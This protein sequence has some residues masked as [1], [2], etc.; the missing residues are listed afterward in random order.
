MRQ[1]IFMVHILFPSLLF[2]SAAYGQST[3]IQTTLLNLKTQTDSTNK[4][5]GTEKLHIQFDKPYYAIG[6]TI[7]LKAWLINAPTYLLSAKSG[8]L[9]VD[10]ANDSNKVIKQYLLPVQ[11]G[12]SWGN[13]TLDEKEF[14]PG[15]YVIRAYTNW[16]RNFGED[17]FYYKHIQVTAANENNLQVN[18]QFNTTIINGNNTVNA[19]LLFSDIDKRAY[20]VKTL[21]LQ[22]MNGSKRLYNQKL[23]T[24]VDGVL[25]VNFNIPQK[26]ANLSI[27]A[28][29]EDKRA[30]IPIPLN[31]PENTDLQFLPEGGSLVAG[32]KTRIG[33]KA[34]A[35][36][37]KGTDISGTI[38]DQN[39]KQVTSFQSMHN[40]MGSFELT[41]QSG[42]TYS[43]K[44]KLPNGSIKTYPLPVAKPSGTTLQVNNKTEADSVEI[45]FSATSDQAQLKNGYFLIGK[46]RGV[47]C[48]A[49]VVN[50][51]KN[52]TIH[53][54]IAKGLFPSGI[55]H[56]ISH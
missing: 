8:L 46:S 15:G 51:N 43:A 2:Y 1:L 55:T 7:W 9:H 25:N 47:I 27:I 48:Y 23:Q 38:T 20:A 5:Y 54:S 42:E 32:L 35:E 45:N 26:N 16:M 3:A 4:N 28:E 29:S 41:P 39:Q 30:V 49:A 22:V 53:R 21:Q 11:S 17:G 37:G 13:I 14:K 31:R 50:F 12:L 33:F 56:I 10:I 18:T 19:K 52:N 40:G 36:D 44:I 24:G 6:D 34:I